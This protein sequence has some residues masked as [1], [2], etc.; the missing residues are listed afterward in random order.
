M[1][2]HNFKYTFKAL[3][4]NRMLIFWTFAFPIIL[5]TFFNMAFSNIEKSEQ[6]SIIDIAIVQNEKFENNENFKESFKYLGDENS[7]DQLFSIKYVSEQ[8]ASEL[9]EK[10]EISGYLLLTD[11]E[12]KIAVN[13]NGVNQTIFKYVTE[14]IAQSE[15]S[16]A[17]IASKV[18]SMVNSPEKPRAL[19][20]IQLFFEMIMSNNT[21][22]I[23]TSS[24]NLSYT[25]IEYYTLIAMT[26]LYGGI[27]GA[28]AM[29]WC[30]ANMTD[31]GKR[32]SISPR[33]KFKM[34]ISSCMA[35]YVVQLIGIAILFLFT[36]MVLKVD[37]GERFPQIILLTMMGCLAG[38]TLGLTITTVI[39]SNENT[40]TGILIG[41]T[42]LGC[43]FSGMMGITM[44][45]VIDKNAPII[46]QINPANMIT[47]G[48]YSLYYYEGLDRFYT[49]VISLAIFSALMLAITI[50]SLRKQKYNSI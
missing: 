16:Y 12:P 3:F 26:C 7:D 22:I 14:E 36:T 48:F 6:L 1:F 46:N 5:S 29:G 20:V 27:L 44:K 37:Y 13:K 47:D 32:A 28:V 15:G 33:S 42:M 49:N 39:K 9:L 41:I 30:L 43:Y 25:M 40:K 19:G 17:N 10:D 18:E 35:S 2:I 38:L 11:D 45:Y 24:A 34:V 21:H 31:V 8:E 4:K 50:F 23:D